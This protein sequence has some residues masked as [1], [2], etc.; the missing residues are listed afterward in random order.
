MRTTA[1]LLVGLALLLPACGAASQS[2]PPDA[3]VLPGSAAVQL[4]HQC[5][6]PAPSPGEAT[7]TPGAEDIERLESA[8][9]DAIRPRAEIRRSHYASDP[10]WARVPLGWRRQYVGIV[11]GGR[12][13]IYGNFFPRRE[14]ELA[15]G[16][17]SWPDTDPRVICDGGA[18]FFGAEYDV[19]AGRFTQLAFNGEI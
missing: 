18:I 16:E 11:R 14:G 7:W 6:R 15:L 4:L 3:L 10:D 12:R 9:A 8:L 5:S 17:P 13:F 2:L 1:R 19:E